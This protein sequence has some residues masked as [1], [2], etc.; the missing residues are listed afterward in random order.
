[1][2]SPPAALVTGVA[3]FLGSHLAELL[4]ERGHVVT[5]LDCFTS[6]YSRSQKEAN[7]AGLRNHPR[8][9]FHE[10]DLVRHDLGPLV[11][12]RSWIFHQAAQP[13]VRAS[14]EAGF[15]AYVENNL[16]A[17]HRLLEATRRASVTAFV[18]ASSSSVYGNVPEGLVAEDAPLR[19]LSPYGVSKLASEEL[20]QV[21]HREFSLPTVCLRYF[22]VCGPRQRPDMAFHRMLRALYR[23]EEFPQNGDGSQ[24]RDFTCVSDAVEANLLAAERGK[25]GGVYNIGGGKPQ[26]LRSAIALLEAFT[27]KTLRVR[28]L[29][30]AEGDPMRT[31]ADLTRAAR[32]LGYSPRVGL[33]VALREEARWFAGPQGPLAIEKDG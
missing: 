12:G 27:G 18:F 13:G 29:L 21:Y 9:Q 11:E 1:M 4:L 22:T 16:L 26:S 33:D 19:P 10:A 17:T 30:R 23:G 5:G 28:E 15:A 25:P 14:W 6:Y 20:V 8:F 2:T 3:G 32:D 31:A 7:L 24:E